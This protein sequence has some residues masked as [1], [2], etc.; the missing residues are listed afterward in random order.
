M[1]EIKRDISPNLFS[2]RTIPKFFTKDGFFYTFSR[3][4]NS[5]YKINMLIIGI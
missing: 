5:I 3:Y 4:N 1:G 2:E